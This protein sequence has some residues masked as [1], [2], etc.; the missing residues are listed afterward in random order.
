MNMEQ[1]FDENEDIE[2][3][4]LKFTEMDNYILEGKIWAA[5]T[6]AGWEL[7]KKHFPNY[8]V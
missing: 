5:Q 1:H 6:I 8:F 2:V 7:A 4:K 3:V